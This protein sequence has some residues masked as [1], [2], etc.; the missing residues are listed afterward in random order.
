MNASDTSALLC[1]L[2]AAQ[3]K[4]VDQLPYTNEIRVIQ[5]TFNEQTRELYSEAEIYHALMRLRKR[6]VLPVKTKGAFRAFTGK[7]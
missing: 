2:Y 7:D 1:R 6:G 3:P 4:S 5:R